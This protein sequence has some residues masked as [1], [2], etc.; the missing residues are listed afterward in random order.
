MSD[1][2]LNEIE[3]EIKSFTKEEL[4]AVL[5]FLFFVEVCE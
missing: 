3:E 1:E 2:V 5:E 4:N